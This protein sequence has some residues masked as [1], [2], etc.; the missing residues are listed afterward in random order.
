MPSK[1]F[2]TTYTNNSLREF[3]ELLL[4]NA[5]FKVQNQALA[6]KNPKWK[7]WW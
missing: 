6:N 5:L 1:A 4:D 2:Q 3:K 7:K